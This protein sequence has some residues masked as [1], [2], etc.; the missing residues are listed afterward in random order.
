MTRRVTSILIVLF[1]ALVGTAGAQIPGTLFG[2]VLD[3]AGQPLAAVRI[4]ITN[5]ETDN[6]S[7]EELTDD[8]GR[9]NIFLRDATPTYI[10]AFTKDGYQPLIPPKN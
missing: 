8:N 10:F 6:F 1:L 9:F 3:E 5:P 2:Q 7:Q 4:L